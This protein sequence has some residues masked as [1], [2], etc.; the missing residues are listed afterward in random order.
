[1]KK[2][3]KAR[4]SSNLNFF[5]AGYEKDLVRSKLH[6]LVVSIDGITQKTYSQYRVGGSLPKVLESVKKI[7]LEKKKQKSRFPFVTWQFIIMNHNENEINK[8]KK[9][10][11]K[12]GFDRIVFQRNRGDMGK[13]LFGSRKKQSKTCHFL[14]NQSVINWNGSVSPC[15]LYYDEK[16][17]FG[18]ALEEGF[19]RV[20]NNQKYQ[21]ARR[22]V[23][24]KQSQ[25]KNLVCWNCIRKG[26]PA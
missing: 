4:I 11:K 5:P 2:K 15:C 23:I 7:N 12:W 17:D 6:H 16:Y 14:W 13:E 8:A 10:A 9:L 20:W 26:F 1:H 21:E 22:L 24:K 19:F 25:D 18:N 3:I